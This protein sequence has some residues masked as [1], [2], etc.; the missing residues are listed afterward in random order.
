ME[1]MLFDTGPI[2]SLVTNNLLWT[3]EGLKAEFNGEFFIT[4][5][6]YTE[7]IEKPIESRRF[8]L[9]ALQVLPYITNKLINIASVQ[10]IKKDT[11]R[12]LELANHCFKARGNWINIVH[13]T[14]IEV[15]ATALHYNANTVV[16]D[17]RTTRQLI[18]NPNLIAKHIS[19]KTHSDI[20]VNEKNIRILKDMLKPL[21]VIRSVELI[22]IAYKKGLLNK[23]ILNEERKIIPNLEKEV[24]EASLWALKLNGCSVSEDEIREIVRTEA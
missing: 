5:S 8:K 10:N 16:I 22:T 17:E 11:R 4:P 15:L 3:L 9:E 6:V 14:E 19:L 24:L 23:Y 21:K 1:I 2:I 20:F 18:E 7:L 13:Y 12:I